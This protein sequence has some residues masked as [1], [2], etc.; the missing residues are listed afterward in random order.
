MYMHVRALWMLSGGHDCPT[1]LVH[2]GEARTT[3][4]PGWPITLRSHEHTHSNHSPYMGHSTPSDLCSL[5]HQ[6]SSAL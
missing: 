2:S 4:T 3:H 6:P 5:R 1:A